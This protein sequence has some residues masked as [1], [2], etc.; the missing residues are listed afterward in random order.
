MSISVVSLFS[1]IGSYEKALSNLDVKFELVHYCEIDEKISK[2]YS[3]I[4]GIDESKNLKDVTKINIPDL[5]LNIDLLVY[6]PPCQDISTAGKHAGITKETRTGLM[7]S[8][9]DI[10]KEKKPRYFVMENVKNLCG[11]YKL[12]FE[13]Y[14]RIIRDIGY[15]CCYEVLSAKDYG[16]PQSRQRLFLVGVR[17]DLKQKFEM[18]VKQSLKK[19]LKDYLDD[20]EVKSIEKEIAYTIRLGG[21]KSKIG[22]K[23]NWDGYRINGEDYYL[24]AKDCLRLMGFDSG[25]YAK[26]KNAK[27]SEGKIAKVAG[28][29]IV[30]T[31][32]E[33]IFKNLNLDK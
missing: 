7:W 21:R 2:C 3:L 18:P 8:V 14:V 29:S 31:V 25:D 1:G 6:S 20:V 33:A 11:K 5:P 16:M 13:E 27:I 12:V 22:N 15:N 23:H 9:I 30:V 19:H 4:H 10:I 28:N 32:L 26:L 24:S 17:T